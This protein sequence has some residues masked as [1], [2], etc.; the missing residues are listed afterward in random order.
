MTPRIARVGLRRS[1]RASAR[2]A[3]PRASA[4]PPGPKGLDDL[5]DLALSDQGTPE[6]NKLITHA[7]Y[8]AV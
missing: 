7:Q 4:D 5:F 1:P 6:H 2:S 8:L 3:P